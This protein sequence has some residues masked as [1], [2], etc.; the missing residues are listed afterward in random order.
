LEPLMLSNL[1]LGALL[2][3]ITVLVHTSALIVVTRSMQHVIHWARLH[4]HQAGKAAAMVL[5][6]LGLFL[7]HAVEIW[8]WAAAYYWLGTMSSF[9]EALYYSTVTFSTV[10]FG[11]VTVGQE[12]RLFSSLEGVNGFLLIGWSTAYL[13]SASTRYGPFR[14][15]EHF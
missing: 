8:T 5:T 14:V 7:A 12:W 9:E 10:G 11:D 1:S 4:L 2:I 6:V 3:A 13:V 15:G